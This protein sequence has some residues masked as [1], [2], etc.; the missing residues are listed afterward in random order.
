MATLHSIAEPNRIIPGAVTAACEPL[1][2]PAFI[3]VAFASRFFILLA[4]GLIWIGP[5]SWDRRFLWA[6]AAW[7]M[8]IFAAWLADLMRLPAP[9]NIAI[10]RIWSSPLSLGNS[11]GIGL[12][13]QNQSAVSLWINLEDELPPQL[14]GKGRITGVA[15]SPHGKSCGEY[16]ILPEA[17]GDHLMGRVFASYQSSWKLVERWAQARLV[18]SVRVYPNLADSGRLA[19][20]LARSRRVEIEVRTTRR[21]GLGR[22]FECLRDYREGD[23]LHDVSWPASARHGRLIVKTY[24]AERSQSVWIV[25]DAGRLML[26]RA[27]R[28][29]TARAPAST[30]LDSAV[31]AALG[32]ARVVMESGDRVGLVA[33]GRKL[34]G[35]L[36][37]ARGASHLRAILELLA[38]VHGELVEANHAR[39]VE[40]VLS[41]RGQ[42]GLVVWLTD[43]AETAATPPVIEQVERMLRRNLVIFAAIGQPGLSRLA[44]Q[45]PES[46][47]EMYRIAAAQEMVFRRQML[48]A[49]L[50]ASGAMVAELMPG[51]LAEALVDRYLQ[52]KER[53]LL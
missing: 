34:Q 9:A 41:R 17:R 21:V 53:S 3:S 47:R 20:G 42:R 39:A 25:I 19:H 10:A 35:Q 5:A 43:L 1:R 38:T 22:D 28:G 45:R 18:Q 33:Y 26:A 40:A 2:R 32:L 30:K 13:I 31:A 29:D 6:M 23:D 50:R 44:G 37:P 27:G 16:S 52:V 46:V 15:V 48:L 11:A 24:R 49:R 4:L 7:D 36:G 8:L 51:Q 14:S 12:E